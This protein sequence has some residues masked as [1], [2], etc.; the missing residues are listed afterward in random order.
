MAKRMTSAAAAA[1]SKAKEKEKDEYVG[2]TAPG[3][4][5]KKHGA[6]TVG[7]HKKQLTGR[8]TRISRIGEGKV[9][10]NEAGVLTSHGSGSWLR[11]ARS[12]FRTR[13]PRSGRR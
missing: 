1:V 10:N 4:T 7:S 2:G 9:V 12:C 11:R 6:H 13:S 3:T 5:V 8:Q